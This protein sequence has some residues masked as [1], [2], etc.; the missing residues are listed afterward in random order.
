MRLARALA[1]SAVVIVLASGSAAPSP[2]LTQSDLPAGWSL[3]T[4]ASHADAVMPT[5]A[6]CGGSSLTARARRAGGAAD[7]RVTFIADSF[8]GPVLNESRW[9]FP[10]ARRATD[11]LRAV[12]RAARRCA[13]AH[14]VDRLSGVRSTVAVAPVVLAAADDA[15]RVAQRAEGSAITTAGDSLYLRTGTTVLAVTLSGYE[16]DHA[17]T[18]RFASLALAKLTRAL[19]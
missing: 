11:F 13:A 15:L 2:L 3:E 4:V 16:V 17:L 7:G 6:L 8:T 10:T 12:G 18:D 5:R 19:G 14:H 1:A 9:G